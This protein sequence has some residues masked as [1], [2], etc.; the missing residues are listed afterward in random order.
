MC[1]SMVAIHI[2]PLK[3]DEEKEEEEDGNHSCKI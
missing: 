2:Q 3:T 1:G